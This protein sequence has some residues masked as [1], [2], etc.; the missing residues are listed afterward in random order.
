MFDEEA[1]LPWEADAVVLPDPNQLQ[2]QAVDLS[3]VDLNAG[4]QGWTWRGRGGGGGLQG[5][6]WVGGDGCAEQKTL[7]SVMSTSC[8]PIINLDELFTI[9]I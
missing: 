5:G 8:A 2:Q 1:K 9:H 7:N 6:L 4:S 3:L